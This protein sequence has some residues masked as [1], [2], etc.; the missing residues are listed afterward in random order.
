MSYLRE[1]PMFST[2]C[3][4]K[5]IHKG[6][7]GD[8]KYYVTTTEN[9]RLLLRISDPQDFQRKQME[10]WLLKQF[11][12]L[13]IPMSQPVDF[14]IFGEDRKVYTLLTWIDGEEAETKV[15]RFS[16]DE[17][18]QIGREAGR[19]LK[20]IHSI[21]ANA[22]DQP[23]KKRYFSV[24]SER[25]AAFLKEGERFPGWE[26]MMDYIDSNRNLLDSR[27]QV[28]LHGDYHMGNL[29]ISPQ[30]ELSVIDWHT[31]DFD[32]IGDPWYEFNRIGMEYPY[33]AA[34]QIDGYFRDSIPGVFWRLLAYYLSVSTI[35]SIVWAKYFA[36][37]R[38]RTILTMN[39][40]ILC[41]FDNMKQLI[42]TW[43]TIAKDKCATVKGSCN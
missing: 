21:P 2:F 36:P 4:V 6:M 42:P 29:I 9:Q 5:P 27:P 26:I 41:Q 32:N 11:A 13:K 30:N 14:G 37:E 16:K 40:D 23:W 15:P 1:L 17:Q 35:T 20:S 22:M 3:D 38:L 33:F 43:Y 39:T 31:V 7:S 8:K 19:I 24:I 10:Y 25:L 18:Y 28:Y 34:G 12:E